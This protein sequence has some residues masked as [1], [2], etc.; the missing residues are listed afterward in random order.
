M[1]DH[2]LALYAVGSIMTSWFT[3]WC[4]GHMYLR[5]KKLKEI[6]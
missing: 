4:M 2:Q 5:L 1:I 6:F 3:G